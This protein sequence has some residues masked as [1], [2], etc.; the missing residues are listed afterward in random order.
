MGFWQASL[1]GSSA[2]AVGDDRNEVVIK[3]RMD[4]DSNSTIILSPV[5][6]HGHPKYDGCCFYIGTP[7]KKYYFLCAETPGAARAWVATLR[8][9]QLVLRVHKE[10]IN[11]ICGNVSTTLQSVAAVIAAA[12]TTA[13]EASKEIEAAMKISIGGAGLDLVDDEPNEDHFDELTIMKETLR[14]KDE[15]LQRLAKELRAKDYALKEIA[16]KLKQTAEA[17]KAAEDAASKMDVERRFACTE[18]ERLTE[19]AEK[20]MHATLQKL[21]ESEE[22]VM[23]LS[24]EREIL[25]KQRDSA[26]QETQLWRSELVKAKEHTVLLEAVANKAEE[27]ARIAEAES[28]AKSKDAENNAMVAAREKDELQALVNFLQSQ[29]QRAQ[30]NTTQVFDEKPNSCSMTQHLSDDN[31]DKSSDEC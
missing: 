18:I 25:L 13:L 4:F 6:F 29:L 30:S 17:A 23:A 27:R 26:F 2:Q 31:V 1:A 10:T 11:S 5:N 20:Q 16:N 24:K 3:G 21:K 22:K 15:E 9:S 19:D 7:Q 12:N 28:E 14:V 8:A